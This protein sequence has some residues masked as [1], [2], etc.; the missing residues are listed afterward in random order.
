MCY[1]LEDG[2]C[3]EISNFMRSINGP[4]NE[5]R[6]RNLQ[7]ITDT[8]TRETQVVCPFCK[9]TSVKSENE[10]WVLRDIMVD[11]VPEENW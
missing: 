9:T 3:N 6:I 10:G 11:G 2:I 8:A 7:V 1:P 4:G 5:V